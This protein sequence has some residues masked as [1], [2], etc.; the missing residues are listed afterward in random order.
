MGPE[1]G[2]VPSINVFDLTRIA[3]IEIARVLV[4]LDHVARF[5]I[6]ANHSLM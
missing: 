6:N 2:P 5:I 4:S 3:L 1:S